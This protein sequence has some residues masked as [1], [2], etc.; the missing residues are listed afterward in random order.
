LR[1]KPPSGGVSVLSESVQV[2]SKLGSLAQTLLENSNW[3]GVAMVEFKV[4]TDG[5]PY[6]MEIN[7]RF[8]GS[9]QLAIDAGVDLAIHTAQVAGN[10]IGA[11]IEKGI[12][13][14][15]GGMSSFDF[16]ES[17]RDRIKARGEELNKKI[18][19]EN[20]L[21]LKPTK[22]T[23]LVSSIVIPFFLLHKY[24]SKIT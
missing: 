20:K 23:E 15:T 11:T 21:A 18:D 1:E 9:L 3:H 14:L 7:T 6:L 2:N 10:A 8:W 22:M 4:A 16:Y 19:P 13:T 5:T 12:N 24:L 17:Q